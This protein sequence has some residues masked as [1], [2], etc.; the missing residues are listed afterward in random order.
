MP[1]K[2]CQGIYCGCYFFY[3]M[4]ILI[5]WRL[6]ELLLA[7]THWPV[8]LSHLCPCQQCTRCYPQAVRNLD[9]MLGRVSFIFAY[10][11][12]SCSSSSSPCTCGGQDLSRVTPLSPPSPVKVCQMCSRCA[13]IASINC[14]VVGQECGNKLGRL[15]RNIRSNLWQIFLLIVQIFIWTV[16]IAPPPMEWNMWCQ[17][18]LSL[19]QML[20]CTKTVGL[21]YIR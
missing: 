17:K 7:L 8:D 12:G 18:S 19:T 14:C 5:L 2:R 4:W 9:E 11:L 6:V 13:S 20:W 10:S 21:T 16:K 15:L 1:E 3:S